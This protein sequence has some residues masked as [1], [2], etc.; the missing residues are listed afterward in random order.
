MAEGGELFGEGSGH[1]REAS[2]FYE[3][4]DFGSDEENSQGT[5]AKEEMNPE[6]VAE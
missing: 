5:H 1:I 6:E 3:R 4:F 2:Y